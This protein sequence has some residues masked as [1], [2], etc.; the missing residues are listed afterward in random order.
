[1]CKYIPSSSDFLPH[2]CFWVSHI[3]GWP[4]EPVS[5]LQKAILNLRW[6]TA[7]HRVARGYGAAPLPRGFAG[8]L[9]L[10]FDVEAPV[11]AISHHGSKTVVWSNCIAIHDSGRLPTAHGDALDGHGGRAPLPTS[12]TLNLCWGIQYKTLHALE[13]HNWACC[14]FCFAHRFQDTVGN[15]RGFFTEMSYTTGHGLTFRRNPLALGIAEELGVVCQAVAVWAIVERNVSEQPMG[16]LWGGVL[17]AGRLV[18]GDGQTLLVT[19]APLAT[20]QALNSV[21]TSK[22]V[23]MRLGRKKQ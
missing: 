14:K 9:L 3:V 20:G 8:T 22:G 19:S 1:M 23:A 17:H 18:T 13:A 12:Q 10:P 11:A 6:F 4:C 21:R 5:Y 2:P 15:S 16:S 7:R